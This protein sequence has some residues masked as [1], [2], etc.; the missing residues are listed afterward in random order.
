MGKVTLRHSSVLFWLGRRYEAS[1]KQEETMSAG[2]VYAGRQITGEKSSI[3]Q[4]EF[5]VGSSWF[6]LVS[7][8]I[9]VV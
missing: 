4:N 1:D 5:F 3:N 8:G 2:S 9:R 7:A 6:K